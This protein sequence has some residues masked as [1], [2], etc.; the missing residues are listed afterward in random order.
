MKS[1]YLRAIVVTSVILLLILP[2]FPVTAD[3]S[4]DIGAELSILPVGE[5]S[6]IIPNEDNYLKLKYTDNFGMNWTR[7]QYFYGDTGVRAVASFIL[8]RLIWPI[9]HPTWRPY[10]GYTSIK[11]DADVVGDPDG[12]IASVYPNTISES[13]DGTTADLTL[14]VFVTDLAAENTVTVRVS[15]TRILKNGKEYGTSYFDIPVRSSKLNFIEVTP[16]EEIKKTAPDTRVTFQISI[17]NLGYFTDTFAVKLTPKGGIRGGLSEQSFVLQPSETRKV[18]LWVW[19][20][21]VFFDPGTPHVLNI[22]AYSLKFPDHEFTGGVQVITQGFYISPLVW[23]ILLPILIVL[24]IIFLFFVYLKD[25]R[26]RERFGKPE[27]PWNIPEERK[28]L[29]QLKKKDTEEYNKVK[30]MMKD[31]Y[32]SALLWYKSYRAAMK[33]QEKKKKLKKPVKREEKQPIEAK[34]EEEK[35]PEQEE[36]PVDF[37]PVEEKPRIGKEHVETIDQRDEAARREK[38]QIL[39]RIKRDQVKQQKRARR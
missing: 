23:I 33:T 37:E 30:Q 6:A 3:E 38:E 22:T 34:N 29:E 27:K 28:H 1:K 16:D 10:L 9:I 20:P 26:D 32:R 13:T 19:T 11:L 8:T 35:E 21:E 36:T 31:E 7:L 17:T 15:A 14:N 4:N 2:I 5:I 24:I 18:T 39:A 12:W 25:R